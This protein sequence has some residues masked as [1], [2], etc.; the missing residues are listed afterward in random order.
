MSTNG[1]FSA[2]N[3]QCGKGGD[4]SPE[5]NVANG[6]PRRAPNVLSLSAE[7]LALFLL[8]REIN[9]EVLSDVDCLKTD[10]A[11]EGLDKGT[12]QLIRRFKMRDFIEKLDARTFEKNSGNAIILLQTFIFSDFLQRRV[13]CKLRNRVLRFF[14]SRLVLQ[15]CINPVP[16]P[17]TIRLLSRLLRKKTRKQ[18]VILVDCR[19]HDEFKKGH[20]KRALNIQNPEILYKIFFEFGWE[21]LAEL[22][23]FVRHL[24]NKEINCKNFQAIYDERVQTKGTLTVA[25]KTVSKA[26]RIRDLTGPS[27]NPKNSTRKAQKL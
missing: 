15:H 11:L 4:C 5:Q 25:K 9:V 19:T 23:E 6:Q 26:G 8:D 3:S 13:Q 27:S 22:G 16:H 1:N 12:R 14:M 20:L 7:L 2:K 21:S 24:E 18:K 17:R 10:K